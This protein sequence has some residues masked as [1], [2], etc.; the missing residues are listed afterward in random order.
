MNGFGPQERLPQE[1]SVANVLGISLG[2]IGDT[3]PAIAGRPTLAST[4]STL[5]PNT[6]IIPVDNLTPPDEEPMPR[7]TGFS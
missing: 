1:S 2:R 5:F 4:T 7:W 6:V 3:A